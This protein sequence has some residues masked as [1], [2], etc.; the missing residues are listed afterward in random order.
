[1]AHA[2]MCKMDGRISQMN[3]VLKDELPTVGV[4]KSWPV[5]W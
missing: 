2:V 1:M 3:D 5:N 4:D